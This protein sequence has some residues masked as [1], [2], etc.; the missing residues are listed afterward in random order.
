[1]FAFHAVS[2]LSGGKLD[3]IHLIWSPP[4]PTGHALDGF[5]IERRVAERPDRSHCFTLS[6]ADLDRARRLGVLLLPDAAVWATPNNQI[7]PLKG[8]WTFR[9]DLVQSTSAVNIAAIVGLAGFAARADGKVIA[10]SGFSGG[11]CRL[12]G[13]GIATV[14]FVVKTIDAPVT[15]CGE[16]RDDTRWEAAKVIV[17]GLQMPFGA[18]D[19]TLSGVAEEH[20]RARVQAEPEAFE[21][22]FDDL[23]RYANAALARPFGSAAWRVSVNDPAAEASNWDTLPFGLVTAL[24]GSSPLRRGLGLGFIDHFDLTP[25]ES[26]DYRIRG[27]VPRADRDEARVDF[28]TVPRGYALPARFGLG[29][30]MLHVTPAPVVEAETLALGG[31]TAQRKLIRFKRLR[32][33]L[34]S[35]RRR[36]VLDGASNGLLDVIG[37]RAGLPIAALSLG[38]EERTLLEFGAPVDEVLLKGDGGALVGLVADPLAPGLDPKEPVEISA[39]VYGVVYQPGAPPP[40][41]VSID[42]DNLGSA[43]RA[44][45]RAQRDDHLGLEIA[46]EPPGVSAPAAL[47]LWPADALS[48]PPTEVAGYV[49]ERSVSGGPFGGLQDT[50]GLHFGARN[51]EPVTQAPT[52]GFDLLAA[53]PPADRVGIAGDLSTRVIDVVE[54]GE[55]ALGA[56]VTYRVASLDVIGR[57]SSPVTSSPVQLRKL[58]RPPT[59]IAPPPP[60]AI[61][62]D[63]PLLGQ[64]NGIVVRL[65]QSEDRDLSDEERA[66]IAADGEVVLLRWGWGPEQRA[67]DPHVTEF[68]IYEAA[69]RLIEILG[70]VSGPATATGTG[71][72]LVPCA[73]SRP[74]LANEFVGR[75]LVLG[76]AFR[77]VGHAAGAGVALEVAPIG[78]AAAAPA[79][80]GGFTLVRTSGAEDD[81]AY[82]DSRL[83]AVPRSGD[84]ADPAAIEVYEVAL[85]A[86]W[87]AVDASRPTQVR[88]FGVSAADDQ[89]YAPD[90]RR[91]VEPSPRVGNEGAVAHG[92]VVARF[93]SRPDLTIADLTDVASIVAPRAAGEAVTVAFRPTDLLPP[94]VTAGPLTRIERCPASAILPRIVVDAASIRLRLQTG[95][96]VAWPL[97]AA[98][99]SALRAGLEARTTPDRFLA[100][101]AQRLG[102][103]DDFE[104]VADADPTRELRDALPNSPVRWIYRLRALDAA[105][106]VSEAAQVLQAVV[107]TPAP[108]PALP[109]ELR[110]LRVEAGLATV[111]LQ[112][113]TDG[114]AA[115]FVIASND[116]RLRP[117]RADL[118]TIRNR[119]DLS[120]LDALVVRD[121]RGRR[122]ALTAVT[123]D[124]DG[125]VEATF[126]APTGNTVNVWALAVS[127]DGIPSRL[128]G[129]L[130]APSGFP[131]EVG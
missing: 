53:F 16:V 47:P 37:L 57:R 102:P 77:I 29:D 36:L 82:W 11:A 58:T 4:F 76:A 109:P 25:G 43:A 126:P 20:K 9:C 88:T 17:S 27:R 100:A 94:G 72:W 75:S 31:L 113:R 38:L 64:P 63:L 122:L 62:P 78:P 104:R 121:D 68:R 117:A 39:A 56:E 128:V 59:P 108:S 23:S 118:A 52:P 24:S 81:P 21:G 71:S 74:I 60:A 83:M 67:L 120:P 101:A 114:A 41:P 34:P 103:L 99:Q 93:R 98:D 50:D 91:A 7:E 124:V 30:V 51:T 92:E 1:M 65:L 5:T 55:I 28:H 14:W 127:A 2:E 95:A 54:A 97:S 85:P 61:D 107:R 49:L 89:P 115:L 119:P 44:A 105:G 66:R 15:V 123:P 131:A 22:V 79:V 87:V 18:V 84:P 46:W 13:A 19:P 80:G 96:L 48:A 129:P 90:R 10:A 70:R 32:I 26:Y 110:S 112:D 130:T 45:R 40:A 69:G 111:R 116:P 8:A 3:G 33:G 73:F 12:V 86:T 125:V 42:V 106:H 6:P 35:P